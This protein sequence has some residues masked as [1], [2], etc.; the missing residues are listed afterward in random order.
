MLVR[1]RLGT[2]PSDEAVALIFGPRLE[3]AR[4]DFDPML[5]IHRAHAIMLQRQGIIERD[6]AAAIVSA[7]RDM[8]QAGLEALALDPKL[9][10]LFYNVEARLTE[11]LGARVAGQLHTGR[12]RNDLSATVLRMRV[13]DSINALH[14]RAIELRDALL[15]LADAHAETIMPGY[16]H[17]KPSQ[18]ITFGYYLTGIAAALERDTKRVERS[19]ETTNLNPLGAAAMAGTSFDLDRDLTTALLG[20]D[21]VLEHCLDAVASRDFALEL[22]AAL[23]LLTTT[24]TRIATDL[25]I[26]Q[27]DEFG[28]V[29]LADAISGTSSIMPQKKNPHPLEQAR[30]RAPQVYGAL[31]TALTATKSTIF[32]N[33]QETG[34]AAVQQLDSAIHESTVAMRLITMV[35]RN[36]DAFPEL[37]EDRA[38][39][40]FSSVTD[41]ADMIVRE[42]KVSFREAHGIVGGTVMHAVREGLAATDITA[43]MLN[44]EARVIL[45]H[46]LSFDPGQIRDTL[47]PAAS[48][49]GKL[50]RGGPAPEEVRRMIQT[51]RERLDSERERLAARRD[52]LANAYAR[53]DAMTSDLSRAQDEAHDRSS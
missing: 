46:E 30:G 51:G 49:G 26:W 31:I 42:Y 25:Y 13:R 38:T 35:A 24:I 52:M 39:R 3:R 8:Q 27:S 10:D 19:Y 2:A 29:E 53:L 50:T 12:S 18:P 4:D 40:D 37:M 28:M 14:E 20:F 36:I 22:I 44:A 23:S 34:Q 15:D 11:Q 1:E 48:V 7:C 21:D 16:T 32:S 41:L 9:E 43:D 5:R 6:V 47:R 45:G 33:N 17:L